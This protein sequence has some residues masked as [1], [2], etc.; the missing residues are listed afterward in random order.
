M[1]NKSIKVIMPPQKKK[2][3][4]AFLNFYRNKTTIIVEKYLWQ[5]SS[6]EE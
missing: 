1:D 2:T 5:K 6:L 3:C 4:K